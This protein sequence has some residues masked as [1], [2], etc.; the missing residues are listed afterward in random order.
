MIISHIILSTISTISPKD[1]ICC[2]PHIDG[3]AVAAA[4]IITYL[5]TVIFK[6]CTPVCVLKN[7]QNECNLNTRN[8]ISLNNVHSHELAMTLLQ[9]NMTNRFDRRI[10]PPSI[11]DYNITDPQRRTEPCAPLMFKNLEQCTSCGSV[12][13]N[14]SFSSL[15]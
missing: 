11:Y 13:M 3:V 7:R 5:K 6:I 14:C 2:C 10:V 4:V 12:A 9:V 15:H 8:D 1:L